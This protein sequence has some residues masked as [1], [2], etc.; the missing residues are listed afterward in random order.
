MEELN[1]QEELLTTLIP[2]G[3]PGTAGSLGLGGNGGSDP[4][5]NRGPGAGGGGGKYGGGGGEAIVLVQDH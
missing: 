5:Y 4:C 2:S 1:F 3:S